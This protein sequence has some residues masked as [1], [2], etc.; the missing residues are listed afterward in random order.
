M[1]GKYF[2]GIGVLIIILSF[3]GLL[4]V[5]CSAP[6][7]WANQLH[8]PVLDTFFSWCSFLGEWPLIS[9]S[10]GYAIYRQP[11]LGLWFGICFL[12]ELFIVQGLKFGLNE[13]RPI[14]ELG[15]LLFEVADNPIAAWKSFP[16]GHTAGAFTALGFFATISS[17][18]IVEIMY[19]ILAFLV[20][21]SRLYLGQHYLHDVA[22]GICIAMF[23]WLI[24]RFGHTRFTLLKDLSW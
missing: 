22:A 9:I 23:V 7:L 13:P 16:S 15:N 8:R 2:F 12:L 11:K 3:F 1:R 24:F 4:F 10:I 5:P 18:R 14:Q 17:R 20:G 21:F 19:V 6:T